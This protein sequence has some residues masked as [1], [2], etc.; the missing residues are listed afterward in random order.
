MKKKNFLNLMKGLL[1]T[2]LWITSLG[3]FAQNIT[4]SGTVKDVNGESLVGVT[5]QVQGTSTGTVTDSDGEFILNNV[6]SNATLEVSYI[7]MQKQ[8]LKVSGRRTIDIVLIEDSE[9]LSEVVVTGFGLAQRKESLTSAISVIG[10]Q[11]LSRS[12]SSTASGA[13]VGKIAGINSRQQDGRP[14][15]TTNIQ[16]RNMGAP[17]YVIDGIQ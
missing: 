1:S 3:M 4:V 6:A 7:G 12:K 17:L 16:I 2:L 13:L 9:M 11:D 15:S 10:A 14:G 8:T 5:L